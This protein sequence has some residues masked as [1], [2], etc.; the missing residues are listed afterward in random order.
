MP[1]HLFW[2][3]SN[4]WLVGQNVC[5]Q[6]EPLDRLAF[7]IDFARLFD[8]VAAGRDVK[9]ALV[10]GSIP[11]ASDPLW[12]RFNSLG[13]RVIK[14]ERGQDSGKEIA[15]D[16]VIQLAMANCVLAADVPETMVLLT[17][18]G[19]GYSA[20]QGFIKQ[21]ELAHK[22]KWNIEVVSW[23]A[24]CNSYLKAFA[25]T[26]GVYRSL[27]PAYEHVTFIANKRWSRPL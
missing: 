23:D 8:F 12:Q 13:V 20:G 2:D 9:D 24:G 6:R 21:L 26:K 14:Q 1:I 3:N 10:V 16:D 22:H 18:D 25:E 4:I 19:S 11:P 15:V 5:G 27:E 17:G 7:R